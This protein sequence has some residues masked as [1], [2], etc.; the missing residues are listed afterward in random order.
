MIRRLELIDAHTLL[1]D[2]GC[3]LY[4]HSLVVGGFAD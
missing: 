2:F 1:Q 4:F 3:D